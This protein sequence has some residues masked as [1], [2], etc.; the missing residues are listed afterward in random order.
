[1]DAKPPQQQLK[2]ELR[3]PEAE[4]IYANIALITHSASEFI[5]DF[6]RMLPGLQKSRVQARIIMAPRNL[7]QFHKALGENIK[8]FEDRLGEIPEGDPTA[9]TKDIGFHSK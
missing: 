5:I 1:M 6:A 7:K 9:S 8:R 4:G 3:E 2:I